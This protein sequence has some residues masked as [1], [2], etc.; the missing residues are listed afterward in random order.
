V[1]GVCD[2]KAFAQLSRLK[3]TLCEWFWIFVFFVSLLSV[4]PAG[5]L[6]VILEKV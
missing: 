6:A 3:F 4:N 1:C 5:N 2:N